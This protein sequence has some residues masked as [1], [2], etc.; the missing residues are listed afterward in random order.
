M[1][2]IEYCDSYQSLNIRKGGKK[3]IN[4]RCLAWLNYDPCHCT[5]REKWTPFNVFFSIVLVFKET[6]RKSFAWN[7]NSI[8]KIQ[9]QSLFSLLPLEHPL[10]L[11]CSKKKT[12][13]FLWGTNSV[14]TLLYNLLT[15]LVPIY[16]RKPI[17]LLLLWLTWFIMF[18]HMFM[19][20]YCANLILFL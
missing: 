15:F 4:L 14:S 6:Y 8:G 11:L 7:L 5:W 3:S 17:N 9:L 12:F 19:T 2:S 16:T 20:I 13:P 10:K 18:F 1:N